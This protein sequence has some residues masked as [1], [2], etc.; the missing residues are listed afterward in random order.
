MAYPSKTDRQTILAVAMDQVIKNGIDKLAVRS[1][2]SELGLSPNALYRYFDSLATLAAAVADESRNRLLMTLQLAAH[3][4]SEPEQVIRAI[5]GAYLRFAREQPELFSLTLRPG[6]IGTEEEP[7]HMR[8]WMFTLDHVIR[9]YGR[10]RGPEATVAL[11]AFLHG[12]TALEAAGVFGDMKPARSFE[13]G[14]HMWISAA[15]PG[16]AA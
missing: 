5:A 3:G 11:W 12:M 13:F 16:N 9:L 7:S 2:A 6:E 10:E 14:L 4:N 1:V 15:S 8:S